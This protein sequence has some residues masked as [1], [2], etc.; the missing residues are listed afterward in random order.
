MV[1]WGSGWSGSSRQRPAAFGHKADGWCCPPDWG[2]HMPM[3]VHEQS[4]PA[5]FVRVSSTVQ[6]GRDVVIH[7][8]ANLYGCSVGDETRIG[9]FVEVQAGARIGARCKVSSHTFVCSGV[10]I[11]DEVFI[12]HGV[13]FTNDG[14]PHATNADGELQTDADWDLI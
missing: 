5:T 10:S 1:G 8:F 4:D 7:C 14:D 11:E 6:L 3:K 13:M 9:A 12:G 2:V